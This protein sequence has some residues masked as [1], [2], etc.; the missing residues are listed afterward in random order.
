[1]RLGVVLMVHVLVRRSG[2]VVRIR[3]IAEMLMLLCMRLLLLLLCRLLL[4]SIEAR[5]MI[6]LVLGVRKDML[7]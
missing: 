6:Q 1:M 7:L 4:V 5:G 2:C 3:A